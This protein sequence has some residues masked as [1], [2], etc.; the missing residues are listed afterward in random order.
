[1]GSQKNGIGIAEGQIR[2]F[3]LLTLFRYPFATFLERKIFGVNFIEF[4]RFI[5]RSMIN[6]NEYIDKIS[7]FSLSNSEI[8]KK[9][10]YLLKSFL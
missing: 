10:Y 8:I 7:I 9:Y 6:E 1:M 2:L 4:M 5:C 3:I